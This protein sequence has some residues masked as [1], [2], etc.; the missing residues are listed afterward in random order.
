[1]TYLGTLHYFLGLQVLPLCDGFFISWYKYLMDMLA[2]IMMVDCN[3]CYNP[4]QYGANIIKT[5]QTSAV[6][7]T[8]YRQLV[9]D[10]MY[11]THS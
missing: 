3:P 11:L 9:N 10:L 8:F 2:R 5:F 1:M 6:D 4:F 7:A